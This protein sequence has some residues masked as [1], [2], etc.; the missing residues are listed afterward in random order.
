MRGKIA[1]ARAFAAAIVT[2]RHTNRHDAWIKHCQH[3]AAQIAGIGLPLE[4]FETEQTLADFLTSGRH[5]ELELD[6]N[7]LPDEQFWKLFDFATSTFDYEA[8]AFTALERRRLS[9]SS[10]GG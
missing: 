9:Y 10:T 2:F 4:M 6:L 1:T 8:A 5:A 7:A 3:S